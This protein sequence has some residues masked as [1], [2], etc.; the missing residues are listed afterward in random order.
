MSARRPSKPRTVSATEG[1]RDDVDRFRCRA[2]RAVELFQQ[3]SYRVSDRSTQVIVVGRAELL[4]QLEH[5][6]R[7]AVGE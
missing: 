2:D 1:K 6:I 3:P 7:W 5:P 4:S